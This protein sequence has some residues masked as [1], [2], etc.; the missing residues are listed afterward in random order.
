MLVFINGATSTKPGSLT[1][2]LLYKCVCI[3]TVETQRSKMDLYRDRLS[4]C[5][6][7]NGSLKGP[8]VGSAVQGHYLQNTFSEQFPVCLSP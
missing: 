5:G 7:W 4:T 2:T 1:G 6:G 3:K 8:C